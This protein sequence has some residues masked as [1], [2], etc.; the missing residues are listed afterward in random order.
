MGYNI[1]LTYF[2]PLFWFLA[3]FCF[4]LL[5]ANFSVGLS[6]LAF[7]TFSKYFFFFSLISCAYLYLWA[8]LLLSSFSDSLILFIS[9]SDRPTMAL[10]CLSFL[11]LLTC[12]LDSSTFPFLWFVLHLRVHL[13]FKG[14]YACLNNLC[15]FLVMNMNCF[16]L[17]SQYLVPWPGAI[18]YSENEQVWYLITM[19]I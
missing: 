9:S 5:G 13:M 2:F 17:T 7:L 3:T 6:P 12:F 1:I 18:L 15:T 8:S 4:P 19:K 10:T 11:T 14:F 16:P